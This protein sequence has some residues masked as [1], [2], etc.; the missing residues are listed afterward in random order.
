LAIGFGYENGMN[1]WIVKNSW[2]A[3]WGDHGFFKIE[4]GVNMCGISNCNS[5]PQDVFNVP[6]SHIE[7]IVDFMQ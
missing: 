4:R 3:G 1:Y 2:G 7:P 5:Y 6:Q